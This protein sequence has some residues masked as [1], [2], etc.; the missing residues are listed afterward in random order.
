[1]NRFFILVLTVFLL[2]GFFACGQK[3]EQ[4][5]Q[6]TTEE[7]MTTDTTMVAEGMVE[8]D[9]DCGM[10]MDPAK[11]ITY[12][13]GEDTLHFCSEGCKDKYLAKEDVESEEE[14]EM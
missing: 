8:C 4:E 11:M 6:T 10:T 12:V 9:G 7:T 3:Q 13:E 14:T 2:I 5:Q 1:M